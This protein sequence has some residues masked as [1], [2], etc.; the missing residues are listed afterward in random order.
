MQWT[1]RLPGTGRGGQTCRSDRVLVMLLVVVFVVAVYEAM[2][3]AQEAFQPPTSNMHDD[4]SLCNDDHGKVSELMKMFKATQ[5]YN[6]RNM[7]TTGKFIIY[8]APSNTG[9][10]N[11]IP[12]MV[13]AALLA[14]VVGRGL[15]VHWI[16]ENVTSN[17][18][19]EVMAMVPFTDLFNPPFMLDTISIPNVLG[20][21]NT[22]NT[23]RFTLQDELAEYLLCHDL[24]SL[25][26]EKKFIVWIGWRPFLDL[27]LHNPVYAARISELALT[28]ALVKAFMRC[29]FPPTADVRRMMHSFADHYKV[30][31]S[32]KVVGVHIRVLSDHGLSPTKQENLWGCVTSSYPPPP[33][34]TPASSSPYRYFLATDH[35]SAID[36][37]PSE[38]KPYLITQQGDEI[39][40]T[41]KEGI[42]RAL[43]DLLIMGQTVEVFGVR[44]TT[45][46]HAVQTFYEPPLSLY[47]F[48][49]PHKF[50]CERMWELP[51][52]TNWANDNFSFTCPSSVTGLSC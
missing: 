7:N 34:G 47:P 3:V 21:V 43:A 17:E 50:Y 42:Q 10:G 48:H 26:D 41:T 1:R 44:R 30:P 20:L 39:T 37:A 14:L 35:K 4:D 9:L 5:L 49:S 6:L 23:V 33:L 31:R 36:N 19:L 16:P 46:V 22:G 32:Q 11:R 2:Q 45:F 24:V 29:L 27:I 13:S 18:Q 40:R 8:Q 38:I 52:F 15:L 25:Y 12:P 28:P 51:C